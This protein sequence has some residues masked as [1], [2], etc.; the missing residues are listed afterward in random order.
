MLG[1]KERPKVD[2]AAFI[3]EVERAQREGTF[4]P[5]MRSYAIKGVKTLLSEKSSSMSIAATAMFTG[6]QGNVTRAAQLASAA[7][8]TREE[9]VPYIE[10]VTHEISEIMRVGTKK[11]ERTSNAIKL[12][13]K[14]FNLTETELR[15][16]VISGIVAAA[17]QGLIERVPMEQIMSNFNIELREIRPEL[18]KA[19]EKLVKLPQSPSLTLE[20]ASL[21]GIKK[22]EVLPFKGLVIK[23]LNTFAF[24]GEEER[25]E[26]AKAFHIPASELKPMH[27]LKNSLYTASE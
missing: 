23:N 12:I 16:S 24:S 8:L 22:E 3:V 10:Q 5:K 1:F 20:L 26:A 14:G 2:K 21:I 7:G 27:R 6:R 9:T 13:A 25:T 19:V 15:S 11:P 17:N 18:L 4:T